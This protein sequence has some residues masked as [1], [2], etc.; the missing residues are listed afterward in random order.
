MAL[1]FDEDYEVLR[2]AGL[3][4]EEDETNRF[5]I[6]KNFPLSE[7]MYVAGGAPVGSVAIL[8][9]IPPNYNTAGCDMFWV[10]PQL[11]RADGKAIPA[12]SGPNEDSRHHNGIEYCRWSRHWNNKPWKTKV[13]KVQKILDRLEWALKN[14][15]A[16]KK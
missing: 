10:Y 13:D 16:D 11:A 3:E 6:I 1:L 14:P 8:S 15:D 5:L 7:G 9:V 2:E 4:Y 12:V